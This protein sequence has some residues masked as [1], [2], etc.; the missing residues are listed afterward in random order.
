MFF[1]RLRKQAKW[2]FI[3]LALVFAV[4]FVGFGVGSGSTGIGDLFNGKLFGLGGNGSASGASVGKAQKEIRQHP[5]QAKGYRDLATA[6]GTSLASMRLRALAA[7]LR[8]FCHA[9]TSLR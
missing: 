4:G 2:M 7:S 9:N 8:S 6:A 3:L 1:P 5:N